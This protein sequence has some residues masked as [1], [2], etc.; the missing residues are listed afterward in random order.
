MSETLKA[1][2]ITINGQPVIVLASSLF[3]FRVPRG[4][5]SDR[6]AKIRAAGYNAIDVYFPWNYHE[7]SEGKWSFQGERDIAEF[8]HMAQEAGLWV[9]ARPGP[10]ICSE[11]DGGGLPAYLFAKPNLRIRDN[12]PRFLRY[13]GRWFDRILTILAPFQLTRG[14]TVIAVQ[15]ENELDFYDCQDRAG[16]MQALRDMARERDIRVPLIACAGQ[17]DLRGGSG[18]VAGIVPVINIYHADTD[19]GV[20][21]RTLHFYERM[22]LHDLPLW[23]TETNRSH[24]F[25]RR[26]LSAGAKMVGP[27]LQTG[28]ANPGFTNG[29][30]NWGKPLSFAT[31]DYDFG[32]MIASDGSLRVEYEEALLLTRWLAVLG[33]ALALARPICLPGGTLQGDLEAVEGGPYALDLEGGGRLV[34]L[35][36]TTLVPQSASLRLDGET[37]PRHSRL[38]IEAGRCPLLPLNLSLARWNLEGALAY[39]TAEIALAQPLAQGLALVFYADGGGEIALSLPEGVQASLEGMELARQGTTITLTYPGVAAASAR[40]TYPGGQTL[41]IFGLDRAAA[42]RAQVSADGRI[43]IPA[44]PGPAAAVKFPL[45]WHYQVLEQ[46][47]APLD[48]KPAPSRSRAPYLE[49][50]GILRGYGWYHARV[51]GLN[52][53]AVRG[54]LL[55]GAADILSL[56]A[57]GRYLGTLTPGGASAYLPERVKREIAPDGDIDLAVRAEIWGHSNFDD[58]R[59]PALRLNA[60]RGL[61]G[62]V[63]VLDERDLTPNWHINMLDAPENKDLFTARGL[64]TSGWPLVGFGGWFTTRA[65]SQVCYRKHITA[66]KAPLDCW[67]LAFPG[68]TRAVEVSV[69]G[70]NYMRVTPLDPYLDITGHVC[71]DQPVELVVYC[72]QDYQA[73]LAGGVTLLEGI[74]AKDWSVSGLDESGLSTALNTALTDSAA[75]AELP[76]QIPPGQLALL[77]ADF[78]ETS[79][80]ALLSCAGRR[81][82]LSVFFNGRLVGRVWPNPDA[83]YPRFVAGDPVRIYLPHP[84]WETQNRLML[85]VEAVDPYEPG[86]IGPVEI[87]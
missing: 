3:Y 12:D 37:L 39:A 40:L 87:V 60:L 73:P 22:R 70:S 66:G 81:V 1:D 57:S 35:P 86:E 74:S 63:A 23:V 47:P 71:C 50:M 69:N 36:N 26:L 52:A 77:W 30:N 65:P 24:F 85:L 14:G 2:G 55:Q 42:A 33:A 84:W 54:Y 32:G 44:V 51:E 8:L 48:F 13:V 34:A 49:E 5:W 6:M 58:P 45:D 21:K 29:I 20:E 53:R 9:I 67:V 75:A 72:A 19:L 27:Y 83:Q 68:L 59:L 4:L 28:G 76:V 41:L 11:W 43:S 16:Y 10:Y 61:S 7:L 31:T 82:K 46:E 64:N 25:L 80:D 17:G 15:L 18:D 38:V 78:P 62:I 79:S 56:Y